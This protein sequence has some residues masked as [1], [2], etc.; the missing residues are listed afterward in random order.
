MVS[1]GTLISSKMVS[2]S[3]REN[4]TPSS[5]ARTT[6]A[7]VWLAARPT[8]AARACGSRCGV[9]SPIRYGAHKTPSEPGGAP[10][11]SSHKSSYGSRLSVSTT[12]PLSVYESSRPSVCA[13]SRL[14]VC[15]SSRPSVC[16]ASS[17]SARDASSLTPKRSR[18]QRRDSPAACVTPMTCQRPGTAWQKV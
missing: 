12:P 2:V 17:P 15:A 7:R 18:N 14:S 16:A 1:T 13:A 11:A 10:D 6:C 9:L 3:R 4:A 5:I 8:S